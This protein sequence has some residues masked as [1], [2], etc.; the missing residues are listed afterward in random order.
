MEKR[1][2]KTVPVAMMLLVAGLMLVLA[3][4]VGPRLVHKAVGNGFERG[5]MVGVGIGLEIVALLL[6][7]MA[8]RRAAGRQQG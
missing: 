4:G 2:A 7:A 1:A 8:A 3:G 6:G 5:L